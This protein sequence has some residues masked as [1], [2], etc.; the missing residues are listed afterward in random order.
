MFAHG[1]HVAAVQDCNE[2][3]QGIA[4]NEVVGA[5]VAVEKAACLACHSSSKVS[6]DCATCHRENRSDRAPR[7]A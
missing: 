5:S 2:C 6:D 7:T 1:Q 3:H 4:Q